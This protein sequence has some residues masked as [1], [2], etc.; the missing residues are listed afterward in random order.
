[1]Q[2]VG[3]DLLARAAEV[4]GL[5]LRTPVPGAYK[6]VLCFSGRLDLGGSSFWSW[7]SLFVVFWGKPKDKPPILGGSL[8]KTPS[9]KQNHSM[10]CLECPKLLMGKRKKATVVPHFLKPDG[11]RNSLK[12]R[13]NLLPRPILGF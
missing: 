12:S 7:Y 13:L 4:L 9:Q 1:M 8:K 11:L 2:I 3:D 5:Q 6:T 10:S